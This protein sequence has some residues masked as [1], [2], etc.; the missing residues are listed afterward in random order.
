VTIF[1][2]SYGLALTRLKS[3]AG[4]LFVYAVPEVANADVG[5]VC[6]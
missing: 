6:E 1:S 4:V 5:G 3:L 2:S